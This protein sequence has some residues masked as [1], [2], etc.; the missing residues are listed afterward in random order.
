MLATKAE[1]HRGAR[2]E[3]P[4]GDGIASGACH[5]PA[6]RVHRGLPR[7]RPS[8][9]A[10]RQISGTVRADDQLIASLDRIDGGAE[11]PER[12]MRHDVAVKPR[13]SFDLCEPA[14][15]AEVSAEEVVEGLI[16]V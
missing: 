13:G 1:A 8:V 12:A 14:D 3:G 9:D 6:D 2:R 7:G 10:P 15:R 5:H 11:G 4:Q 16:G